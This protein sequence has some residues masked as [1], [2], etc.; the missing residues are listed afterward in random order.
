MR[1][2]VRA[3]MVLLSVLATA[4]R[5]GDIGTDTANKYAWGE[6]VGWANAA[7]SNNEVTVHFDGAS[8]W[9]S[10]YL[11]GEGVGW[12]R[13]G[14]PAGGPYSNASSN[15]WGVNLAADGKLFGYAWGENVGWINFGHALCDAAL[16]PTTGEFSGRAWGE[17]VGWLNFKGASPAYGVRT[18]A[19]DAQPQGTPNWWLDHY[20]VGEGYDAG[21][22]V[23]AWRKYV[24]DVA[25][26]SAGNA[27]RITAISNAAGVQAVSFWPASSRRYY[28]LEGRSD[29]V[30]GSW[31]GVSGQAP[32][33]SGT[34]GTQTLSDS[35]VA[36]RAFYRVS[37]SVT[38]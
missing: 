37:V 30:S 6:N 2:A 13:M 5:A 21:D 7:P 12:L 32:R 16:N 15:N 1:V 29:L 10:G 27:L 31:S 8:G 11:W 23:P 33:V 17:N 3:G 14:S 4:A 19:F 25:P 24:M 35:G 36:E 18:L 9:L 28:T 22:G 34:G 38:P 26:T 20:G